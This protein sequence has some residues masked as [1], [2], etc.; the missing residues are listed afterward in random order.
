MCRQSSTHTKFFQITLISLFII[1]FSCYSP[2]CRIGCS[3]LIFKIAVSCLSLLEYYFRR[4]EYLGQCVLPHVLSASSRS[5]V[6]NRC[7]RLA[8]RHW[9][10]WFCR[11]R[12]WCFCTIML[13]S[14][15]RAVG[16]AARLSSASTSAARVLPLSYPALRSPSPAIT[17]PFTRSLWML[18]NNGASSGYRPKLFSSKV[19][20]PSVSCGCGGL[21]T[22]GDVWFNL[23][24]TSQAANKRNIRW[25][26]QLGLLGS[27]RPLQFKGVKK[28]V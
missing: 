15:V 21:H 28:I 7:S 20:S 16:A 23:L 6:G 1:Y 24:Y 14:V 19:L 9:A 10:H 22:E 13:K 27:T 4:K 18:S 5:S 2:F 25:I 26:R 12:S 17:R 8:L 3:F 11:D